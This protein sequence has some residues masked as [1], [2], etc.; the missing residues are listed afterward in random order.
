M[1]I[2]KIYY[3]SY[4]GSLSSEEAIQKR[5]AML[6]KSMAWA[7][8]NGL[9]PVVFAQ[10]YKE[11]WY[12]KGV[13]YIK[14]DIVLPPAAARN[15]LLNCFYDTDDDYAFISDDDTWLETDG[16]LLQALRKMGEIDS[17]GLDLVLPLRD[18]DVDEEY[19]SITDRFTFVRANKHGVGIVLLKNLRKYHSLTLFYN[20]NYK[21]DDG[22]LICGEDTNLLNQAKNRF[23]LGVWHSTC[24]ISNREKFDADCESTWLFSIT[25]KESVTRARELTKH[26]KDLPENAYDLSFPHRTHILKPME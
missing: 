14:S 18:E 26:L 4:L 20:N 16:G 2:N 13:T 24:M 1:K 3:I 21:W 15:I 17:F 23:N 5:L 10:Q 7:R 22:G 11:S 12:R 6:D 8:E 25:G 19:E 9:E